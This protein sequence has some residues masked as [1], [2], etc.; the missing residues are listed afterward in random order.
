MALYETGLTIIA[1]GY[2]GYW[3]RGNEAKRNDVGAQIGNIVKEIE[4]IQIIA[5]QYWSLPRKKDTDSFK[6]VELECEILGRLHLIAVLLPSLSGAMN[7][8]EFDRISSQVGSFWNETTGGSFKDDERESDVARLMRVYSQGAVLIGDLR[9]SNR[10][11]L[12]SGPEIIIN[13][14]RE[15]Y[16]Y[17]LSKIKSNIINLKYKV[18]FKHNK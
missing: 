6:F 12:E 14:T 15:F 1:G 13:K 5:R 2:F 11:L 17:V 9:S 3:L 4:Q 16:P 8:E 18:I 10:R 7:I